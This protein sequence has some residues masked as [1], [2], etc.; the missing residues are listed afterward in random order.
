MFG[1]KKL[2]IP[3][4]REDLT[5]ENI[6]LYLPN[7]MID[8]TKNKDKIDKN[9]EIYKGSHE[10]KDKKRPHNDD[11][12]INNSII[13]QDLWAMVNFKC[14]YIYGNP[15]EFAEKGTKKSDEMLVLNNYLISEDFRSKLDTVAELVYSTG[16]GYLYIMPKATE[17]KDEE[18]PFSIIALDKGR[19]YKVFSSYIDGEELFDII[20]TK[21]EKDINN[22]IQNYYN[23]AIYTNDYYYEFECPTANIST[24]TLPTKIEK[25]E[26]YKMLPLIEFY[27]YKDKIGIVESCVSLQN[28]IDKL[29]SN[30]LDN[31]EDFVNQMF[32]LLNASL[33]DTPEE[34]ADNFRK[35]KEN[36]VMELNDTS[37]DIKAD[38]KTLTLQ[39]NNS[40]V[41]VLKNQLRAD[42]YGSWGVPLASSSVSSGNITQGGGEVANGWEN[43]Y[44]IALKEN[45]KMMVGLNNLVKHILWI[46]KNTSD[47]AIKTLLFND[48][49]IKYNIARS[50]NLQVKT[51]SFATLVENNVPYDV[52]WA[53]CELSGD[54]KSIGKSIQDNADKILAERQNSEKGEQQNALWDKEETDEEKVNYSRNA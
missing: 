42:M 16:V 31:L 20:L 2:Q 40:D 4:K 29:D 27:A 11:S 50:N 32:I 33:G 18:A 49:E 34:K 25:R 48:I 30:S 6:L 47:V 52:A 46:A 43:A 13:Q 44:S 10:I 38:I 14:G 53:T 21:I 45:N 36:G 17:N 54:P 39:L 41:N 37:R 22:E 19:G 3:L 26:K 5:P 8:L 7:I 9:Y 51:Q 23:I 1:L 28:A 12:A 15:L 24:F 35:A